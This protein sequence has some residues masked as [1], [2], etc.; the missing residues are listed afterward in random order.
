[1][2]VTKDL[3]HTEPDRSCQQGIAA[4]RSSLSSASSCRLVHYIGVDKPNAK[5]V[6]ASEVEA[7]IASC[8]AE[9]PYVDCLYDGGQ[10]F[11]LVQEPGCPIPSWQQVKDEEAIMDVDGLLEAARRRGE[12]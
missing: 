8:R 11:I 7:E 5:D 6:A 3:D 2:P 9:G 12:L 1:M 10:L 4:F